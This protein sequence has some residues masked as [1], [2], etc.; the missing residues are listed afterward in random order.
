MMG[1][2]AFVRFIFHFRVSF[3]FCPA[4]CALGEIFSSAGTSG[5]EHAGLNGSAALAAAAEFRGRLELLLPHT[6]S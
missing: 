3:R 6:P 5:K 2:K 4:S 1:E